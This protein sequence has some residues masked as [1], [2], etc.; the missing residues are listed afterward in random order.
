MY[1]D[2]GNKEINRMT[3]SGFHFKR[4]TVRLTYKLR[5]GEK[6]VNISLE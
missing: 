2:K 6:T 4:I 1:G 3:A 5:L